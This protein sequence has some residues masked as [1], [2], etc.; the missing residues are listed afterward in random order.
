MDD[1][2][3]L[4]K[5]VKCYHMAIHELEKI[6]LV[7]IITGA[8]CTVALLAITFLL[9]FCKQ[10]DTLL[11][12]LVLYTSIATTLRLLTLTTTND[13]HLKYTRHESACIWAAYFFDWAGI[14]LGVDMIGLMSYLFYLVYCSARGKDIS[15][16]RFL[17][18]N[19]LRKGLEIASVIFVLVGSFGYASI[20]YFNGTYGFTN[21]QCWIKLFDAAYDHCSVSSLGVLDQVLNGY[22]LFIILSLIIVMFT[23]A[24]IASYSVLSSSLSEARVLVK[25]TLII[26][27]CLLVHILVIVASFATQWITGHR[28]VMTLQLTMAFSCPISLLLFP[29]AFVVC[30]GNLHHIMGN[31]WNSCKCRKRKNIMSVE[32]L[33]DQATIQ[34]STRISP[35]SYTFFTAPY[36]GGFTDLTLSTGLLVRENRDTGTRSD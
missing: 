7:Y 10:F 6:N 34:I 22:V 17:R 8:V 26:L 2:V 25:K 4:L 29:L 13:Y 19:C 5:E 14:V 18:S 9:F 11:K 1:T 15:T 35:R 16:P 21:G 20:P 33:E 30:F 28:K 24:I 12:R 3:V 31:K 23:I 32:D 36:T 27:S